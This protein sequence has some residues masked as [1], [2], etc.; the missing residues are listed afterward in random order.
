M[1]QAASKPCQESQSQRTHAHCLTRHSQW[2]G[3][4]SAS[5]RRFLPAQQSVGYLFCNTTASG[6]TVGWCTLYMTQSGC[7]PAIILALNPGLPRRFFFRSHDFFHGCEKTAWK[8]WV[9][10]YHYTAEVM[11][12][13][14]IASFP[15]S[16]PQLSFAHSINNCSFY[17]V[18]K[19]SWGVETGSEAATITHGE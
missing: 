5:I 17:Y 8:A 16:T 11:L 15:A 10:G 3:P 4:F 19:K 9:R 12:L 6:M 18:R 2:H 1:N 13:S 7:T 14:I